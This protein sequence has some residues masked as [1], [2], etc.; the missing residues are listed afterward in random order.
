MKI[1][2]QSLG[3]EKQ[4]PK[5]AR[6]QAEIASLEKRNR[7][8]DMKANRLRAELAPAREQDL[9]LE[10][11]AI[12]SGDKVPEPK[13]EP[14]VQAKL[15]RAVRDAAVMSRAL[16]D[17]QAE[18]SHF[19]GKH[20]GEL[21]QD[22]AAARNEIASKIAEAAREALASY[23]RY[24]DLRYVL[25]DLTPPPEPIDPTQPAQRLTTVFAGV[26][27]TRS[28]GPD[29]GTVEGILSYLMGL[30]QPVE[31]TG[32]AASAEEVA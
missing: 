14:E 15:D 10:A 27:T 18:L 3:L 25:K 24:E 26:Q 17:A 20:Q 6:L 30:A 29:R 9:S 19:L 1:N 22:V 5:L 21:Y 8:A 16:Q 4:W 7:E 13:H 2:L 11:K 23:G 31:P 12:R 32:S 28:A